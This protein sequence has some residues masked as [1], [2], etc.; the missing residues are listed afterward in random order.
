SFALLIPLPVHEETVL[1]VHQCDRDGHVHGDTERSNAAQ[2]P[3]DQAGTAQEFSHN[4]EDSENAGDTHVMGETAHC[5]GKTV[6]A[7]QTKYLLGAVYEEDDSEYQTNQRES[8]V[9]RCLNEFS[10]PHDSGLL[11]LTIRIAG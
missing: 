1:R 8:V 9:I 10:K 6:S 5:R 2:Q 3:N 7:E 11:Q 4:R